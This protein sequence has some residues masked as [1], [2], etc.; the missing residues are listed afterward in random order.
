MGNLNKDVVKSNDLKNGFEGESN[1]IFFSLPVMFGICE[2]LR[3]T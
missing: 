1:A 3:K 2:D